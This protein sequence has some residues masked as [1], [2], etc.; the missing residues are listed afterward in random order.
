M[1]SKIYLA[2]FVFFVSSIWTT[3]NYSNL[4][5]NSHLE[6]EIISNR[7]DIISEYFE[8]TMS[9]RSH[10]P[11]VFYIGNV[12]CG[13]V[14]TYCCCADGNSY[15]CDVPGSQF[16][17]YFGGPFECTAELGGCGENPSNCYLCCPGPSCHT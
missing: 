3:P 5:T 10:I 6:I 17:C 4:L 7:S 12:G 8:L 2:F 14:P 9:E 1:N 16:V 11:D 15:V 13:G